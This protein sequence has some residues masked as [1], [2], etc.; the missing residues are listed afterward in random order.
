MR[1]LTIAFVALAAFTTLAQH[2]GPPPEALQAC[3]SLSEGA[4]CN[5]AHHGH[6]VSGT[7]RA[8]PKGEA[9]AC[10]PAHR[11]PP[12]EALAACSGQAQGAA[13]SFAIEGKTIN[14]TCFSPP[15]GAAPACRP[16]GG[17]PPPR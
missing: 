12:Q 5:F 15:D 2:R 4:A 14:G 17:P 13:C 1:K 10:A 3:S 9:L 8:G 7:C 6:D 11:G 16:E